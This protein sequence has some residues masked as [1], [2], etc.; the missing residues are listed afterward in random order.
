MK[1]TSILAKEDIIPDLKPAP[2]D[3]ILKTLVELLASNKKV[4][5]K[6]KILEILKKREELVSTAIGNGVAIPHGKVNNLNRFICAFAR[7]PEGTD[8]ES[9][10]EKPTHFFFLLLAPENAPNENL[11]ALAKIARILGNEKYR[12]ALAKAKD[13]AEIY[14][15]FESADQEE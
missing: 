9:L 4:K 5:Q 13:S 6:G 10:D 7:C 11:R 12:S 8:F 2:K 1:I 14:S 3:E 15:L